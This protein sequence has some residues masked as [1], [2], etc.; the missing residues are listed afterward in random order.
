VPT[1]EAAIRLFLIL[2]P[3][4][5]AAY[6]VQAPTVRAKQTDFEKVVEALL[7]SFLI[8]ITYSLFHPGRPL[9]LMWD[10]AKGNSLQ[11]RSIDLLWLLAI[12]LIYALGLI[13]F[14]NKDGTTFLRKIGLTERTSRSSI[15]N[16]VFQFDR[17]SQIVQVEL[18]DGRSLQ[19]I[20]RFYSDTA[21]ESSVFLSNARWIGDEGEIVEVPGPGVLLT[22]EAKI[23]SISFLDPPSKSFLVHWASRRATCP[24]GGGSVV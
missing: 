11:F 9:L 16:D 10:A 17:E 8:Y 1:S 13:L 15:W 20:V 4:L 19:G 3:G 12:T 24:W 6:L 18:A 14:V 2:I 21:E 22:K 23:I 5:A 7:F